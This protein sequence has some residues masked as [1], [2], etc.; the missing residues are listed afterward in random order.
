[1]ANRAGVPA[2]TARVIIRAASSG[3]VA[4]AVSAGTSA[5]SRRT[6][7]STHDF[8]RYSSRSI[9]VCPFGAA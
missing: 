3:L 1:V 6:G 8:G 9:G 4:N 2:A 5:R 7:S